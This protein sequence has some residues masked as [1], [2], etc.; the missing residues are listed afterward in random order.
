MF[1][2]HIT[3]KETEAQQS[4]NFLI[5]TQLLSSR[6]HMGSRDSLSS[7]HF[8]STTAASDTEQQNSKNTVHWNLKQA[9]PSLGKDLFLGVTNSVVLLIMIAP[10]TQLGLLG[11][12]MCVSLIKTNPVHLANFHFF[13]QLLYVHSFK[14]LMDPYSMP[15]TF[16]MAINSCA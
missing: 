12:E 9:D 16:L 7:S 8:P 11:I 5:I 15:S 1:Y 6:S 4:G 2:L 13:A 10:W 14:S 3:V